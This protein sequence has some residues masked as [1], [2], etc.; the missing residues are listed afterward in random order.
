YCS[1]GTTNLLTTLLQRHLGSPQALYT[2]FDEELRKPLGLAHTTLEPD[3]GGTPRRREGLR[4][5]KA[6]RSDSSST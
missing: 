2:F 3:A 5:N 4:D 1:S 6:G